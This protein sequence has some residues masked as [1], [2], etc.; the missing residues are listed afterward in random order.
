MSL[1]AGGRNDGS[2]VAYSIAIVAAAVMPIKGNFRDRERRGNEVVV[3]RRREGAG[4]YR[5]VAEAGIRRG[6][7]TVSCHTILKNDVG[8][9]IMN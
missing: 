6:A 9:G 3:E 2:V 7:N 8:R 4:E 1:C 5:P